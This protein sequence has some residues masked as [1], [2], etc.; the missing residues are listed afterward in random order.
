M[1]LL[2]GVMAILY[3][4]G[5]PIVFAL[6]IATVAKVL[7][8]VDVPLAVIPHTMVYGVSS[9]TLLAAPFFMLAGVLM[10]RAGIAERLTE[11]ALALVGHIRGGL[12]HA[13]IVVGMIMAGMSGSSAADTS[14]IGGV[15]IPQMVKRGY[16]KTF[17]V[18]VTMAS[19]T[20][21]IIIPPSIP[22]VFVAA[23]TDTSAGKL[24]LGG[25]IPGILIGLSMMGVAYVLAIKRG[26]PREKRTSLSELTHASIRAFLPL[27][28]PLLILGGIFWGIVTPTEAATVGVV[29]AAFLG[30]CVYRTL[31]LRGLYASCKEAAIL[32]SIPLTCLTTASVFGWLMTEAGVSDQVVAW[33]QSVTQS[34]LVTLVYI[35]ILFLILGCFMDMLPAILV[36]VPILLPAAVKMGIDPVFFGVMT[37]INFAIGLIT[38]P[39]GVCLFIGASLG[40]MSIPQAARGAVWFILIMI[41]VLAMIVLFPPLVLY[42]PNLALGR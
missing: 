35:N 24:L 12:A 34:P 42:I 23:I 21:G 32:I 30:M 26:Y 17:S 25:I 9:F 1:L 20:I 36:F 22:M 39:F 28:M 5:A 6:G 37:V 10:T 18:G 4:L 16:D 15:L 41:I 2:F 40:N 19:G 8:S 11:F 13:N 38:P 29:Y 7:T 3:A 14:A 27:L 31:S 33:L